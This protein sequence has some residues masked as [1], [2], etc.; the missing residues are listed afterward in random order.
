[1]LPGQDVE[2]PLRILNLPRLHQR[3]HFRDVDIE[4][5]GGRQLHRKVRGGGGS[6]SRDALL[7]DDVRRIGSDN[8]DGEQDCKSSECG[9][10]W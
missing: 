8:R 3:P 9:T 7:N 5:R 2:E 6:R 4:G 10:H 1:M